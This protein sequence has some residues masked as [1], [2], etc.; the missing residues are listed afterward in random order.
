[1]VNQIEDL[2][3]GSL[4]VDIR[5][6][7]PAP[8]A[9]E[10]SSAPP[11]A[12]PADASAVRC[13]VPLG[14]GKDSATVLEVIKRAGVAAVVPFFLSDPEGEFADSWRYAALCELASCEPPLIADFA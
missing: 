7:A 5:V 3:G 8:P 10:A 6:D 12:P 14:G 2:G 11:P 4:V 1:M 9:E 13:L